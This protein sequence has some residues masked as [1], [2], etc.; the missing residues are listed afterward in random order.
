MTVHAEPARHGE[1]APEQPKKRSAGTWIGYGVIGL[2]VAV[3]MVGWAI[4]MG[5]AG[6]S[7]SGIHGISGR[8]ITFV[9]QGESS[10]QM[11][12]QILKPADARVTCT[13]R[14]QAVDGLVVGQQEVVAEPG[15]STSTQMIYLP[16]SGKATMAELRDC[17]RS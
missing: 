3:C 10:V 15:K 11:T 5:N 9:V 8:T 7:R 1:P 12:F 4:V 13:A 17:V 2:F 6:D 16:T 14:A